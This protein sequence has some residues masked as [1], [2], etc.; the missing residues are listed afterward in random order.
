MNVVL[1]EGLS[2]R[3][4][5]AWGVRNA[6]FSV[7]RGELMTL[8]G[9]NGAGKSTTVKVLCTLFKPSGGV[10]QVLGYDVLRD[11]QAVRRGISY[12]PQDYWGFML[13]ELTPLE[14]V[15][16]N[17]V[18]R[19]DYSPRE[20]RR[21]AVEWLSELG[22]EGVL[23]TKCSR[24]SGGQRRRVAVGMALSARKELVFLDEPTSGVDVEAKH[25]V[26]RIMRRVVSQGVSI[27]LTTHDMNEAQIVSDRVVLFHEGNT[28]AEATPSEL[29]GKLPYKYRVVVNKPH[30][31][32]PTNGVFEHH[33]D[34]GDRLIGYT[35]TNA[36]AWSAASTLHPQVRVE[37]V[38]EVGLE[39]AYLYL[40]SR[41]A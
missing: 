28:I 21:V 37:S 17:L 3:Y 12:L 10:V 36:D 25:E 29:I 9:R 20:A 33:F 31:W 13:E 38:S 4:G 39:D 30:G 6:S 27:V 26:W 11:H 32:A 14:A 40:T 34:L 35:H 15:S 19:G 24:L 7:G 5:E 23:E 2:K 41:E 8:L 22:L 1:V 18:A 16:W